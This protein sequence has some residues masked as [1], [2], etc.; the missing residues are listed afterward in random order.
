MPVPAIAIRQLTKRY[1]DLLAVDDLSLE[2]PEGE[3]FGFL[4]PNG[5]GKTT[6]INAVVGLARFQQG[7]IRV[8]GRDAVTEYRAARGSAPGPAS[9]GASCR[10]TA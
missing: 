9:A 2:V 4:G 8:F 7:T 10:R 5:A 1:Q 3:F 6:T